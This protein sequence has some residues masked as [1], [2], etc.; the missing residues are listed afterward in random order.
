MRYFLILVFGIFLYGETI[1]VSAKDIKY[2]EYLDYGNLQEVVTP[3]KVRCEMFDK[4]KLFENKYIASR[5]IVKNTP[6]CTKDVQIAPNHKVKFDFGNIEIERDGEFLGETKE[7]I[8][9]KRPD[10]TIEKI[11]KN[12]QQ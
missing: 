2:K 8:R 10:G 5:Y 6:I 1:L 3:K 11:D 12:G 4:Q 7:Y 9:I